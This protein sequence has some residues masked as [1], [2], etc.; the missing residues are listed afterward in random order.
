MMIHGSP[1]KGYVP[2][3]LKPEGEKLLQRQYNKFGPR[4]LRDFDISDDY[5][6]DV[7]NPT[8]SAKPQA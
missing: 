1:S 3:W 6:S 7:S 8:S 4:K 2:M 5:F